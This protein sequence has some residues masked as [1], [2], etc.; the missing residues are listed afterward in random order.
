MV[1]KQK[2]CKNQIKGIIFFYGITIPEGSHWS[3]NFI[4]RIE[5]ARME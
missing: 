1:R 2:R 3:R 4:N 5:T